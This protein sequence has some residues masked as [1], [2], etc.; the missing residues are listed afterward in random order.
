[1]VLFIV[2]LIV[3]ERLCLTE[4][5]FSVLCSSGRELSEECLFTDISVDL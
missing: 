3:P 1:M 5:G 2:S 4:Y